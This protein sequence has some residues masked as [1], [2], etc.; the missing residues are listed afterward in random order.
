MP[1]KFIPRQRRLIVLT[2]GP[3]E[4][5]K[6]EIWNEVLLCVAIHLRM[7]DKS[8]DASTAVNAQK[9]KHLRTEYDY[10]YEPNTIKKFFKCVFAFAVKLGV[11]YAAHNFK[12]GKYMLCTN[13]VY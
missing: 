2:T 8:I 3:K 11:Q 6:H 9:P 10:D 5:A 1:N 13:Q 7:D 12:D 4:P